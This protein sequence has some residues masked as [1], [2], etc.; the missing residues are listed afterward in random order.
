MFTFVTTDRKPVIV[1]DYVFA[2][3]GHHQKGDVIEHDYFGTDKKL[4]KILKMF[5]NI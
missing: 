2:T 4:L 5:Y 1:D 3:F